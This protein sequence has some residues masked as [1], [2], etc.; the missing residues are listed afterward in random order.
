MESENQIMHLVHQLAQT[1]AVLLISHR[2]ANVTNAD[3]IYALEQGNVMG[4]GTHE[5]LLNTC[6]SYRSLWDSQQALEH[7]NIAEKEVQA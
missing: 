5:E 3:C 6:P 7:Y 4:C 1:K 2:L